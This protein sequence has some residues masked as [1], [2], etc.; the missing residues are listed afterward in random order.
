MQSVN[1][2]YYHW[3]NTLVVV[4][5]V[6]FVSG[7]IAGIFLPGFAALKNNGFTAVTGATGFLQIFYGTILFRREARSGAWL[8]SLFSFMIFT[9][10][11][12]NLIHNTGQLHSLFLALW[13]VHVLISGM[14]GLYAIITTGF[15]ITMYF[16]LIAT[17]EAGRQQLDPIS[18]SVVIVSYAIG[19]ASYLLWRRL[20]IDQES[21]KVQQLTGQL[22]TNKQQAEMLIQSISDGMVVITV[23][24][25][26]GMMNPAAAKMTQW[27]T[28]E[29]IGLDARLV[30]K[31]TSEEDKEIPKGED[32][33]QK[34]FNESKPVDSVY[35]LTGREGK[36]IYVSAAISPVVPP[37]SNSITGAVAVMR[38]ISATRAEERR[39]A[40]FIST[41]SHEMRTPV[42]AIEGYLAL[43]LNDRV[44]SIDSKAR[45]YLEKA[46]SST[47][48]LGKLFQDLLTSARAE[49]GRLV[50]H[51]VV[52]EMGTYMEQLT[53]SLRFAAEKKGLIMDL[54]IG[55]DQSETR[56]SKVIK[57][58]YYTHVDPD[59]MREVITN[60]FDNAVKYTESG[61][62]SIG[63]TGNNSIVQLYVKDTGPGIPA[64]DV[65]HLFQKF[66]RVDNS[67]T[68]TIGGTGLGLFI[69]RKIIELYSGRIWVES[70]F[71]KGSTFYINL[72]RLTAEKA[73]DLQASETSESSTL[74]IP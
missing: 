40:D 57:P 39:R 12:I 31:F 1:D 5:G 47:Q 37:G 21:R 53:D 2:K 73:A 42:A 43:A 68:R 74:Q 23:D 62:I 28:N 46:H 54:V 63:L 20:Y 27:D 61:K 17:G 34:V 8:A 72:P 35:K 70:E 11:V 51:P 14:F 44:S 19:V 64:D 22:K 50:S 52:V 15:I 45:S 58:L 4:L 55:S 69:C 29:A 48:H 41:A 33:L 18:V 38:D 56:G 67:A 36:I 7:V 66:Y 59:R 24:G 9:L 71:G 13:A 26:I 60:V 65:P 16:V 30:L 32:P 25:K 3:Y 49:D 10:S 6:V